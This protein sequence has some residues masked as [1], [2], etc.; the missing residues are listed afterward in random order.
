MEQRKRSRA[1]EPESDQNGPSP[2]SPAP[3]GPA[4]REL[5]RLN[6][7]LRLVSACHQRLVRATDEPALLQGVCATLVGE[8]GCR[9]AWIGYAENDARRSVRPVAYSGFEHGY[10]E[11]AAISWADTPAGRGPTGTAIRERRPVVCRNLLRDPAYLP[12]RE[13]ARARGY[14][15]SVAVPLLGSDGIAGALN[16]YAAEPDAFTDEEVQL[17]GQLAGDLVFGLAALRGRR[18]RETADAA[19]RDS[20]ARLR[21]AQ[22]LGRMGHWQLDLLANV[23]TWSEE[24]YR[25]FEID[26]RRFGAAY[27]SFLEAI[28]PD[29]RALVN[30]AYTDS[31]RGHTPYAITHRLRM[32][33]GRIK[34]VHERGETFYDRQARPVRSIGTVQDITE[35]VEAE[36][37]VEAERQRLRGVL[38]NLPVFLVL[39]TAD[40]RLAFAN[41]FFRDRFGDAGG[42]RCFEHLFGRTEPCPNCESYTVLRTDALH[43]WQWLGPDARDYAMFDLPFTDTDGARMILEVGIDVTDARRA[44]REIR[45]LNARLEDRVRERTAQLVAVNGE[46]EA[47]AYS[48]SHDLRAPLRSIDGFGKILLRDCA[49]ELGPRGNEQLQRIRDATQR[50]DRLIDHLLQLS[51]TARAP[52]RRRPLDLAP[53]ACT[54]AAEL[55]Q[56]EP[57]RRVTWSIQPQLSTRGDPVLV[58]TLLE[59]LLGNAWKFTSRRPEAHIELGVTQ[60]RGARAFFVRDNGAGFDMEYAGKLFRAFQR[61]HSDREFP[62][63]GVGLATVQRIV[64]RHGGQIW[65]EAQPDL[66]ATFYFTLPCRQQVEDA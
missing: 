56:M 10:L 59:N 42:K 9:L 2:A 30:R 13:D 63:T 35:R 17:F 66:G 25:I 14:A 49:A 6:R 27:E 7:A 43:R 11:Q 22:R 37:A 16:L 3:A 61:L 40:R 32:A 26:S 54:I 62:G 15:S 41:R 31:V 28:H 23:L 24:I 29:D 34:Y 5:R 36:Q 58:R 65:A 50:M 64:Q 12:W 55:A 47:F 44:E 60:I 19:L 33:D 8:G 46:L 39:R 57:H 52:F 45:E 1:D 51:H 53:I 20:E 48:V 18:A 21:E 38:E 4:E